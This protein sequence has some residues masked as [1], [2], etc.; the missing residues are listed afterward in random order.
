MKAYSFCS[1]PSNISKWHPWTDYCHIFQCHSAMQ[2]WADGPQNICINF[3]IKHSLLVSLTVHPW[4]AGCWA[5]KNRFTGVKINNITRTFEW[6]CPAGINISI[7]TKLDCKGAVCLNWLVVEK[8]TVWC[9]YTHIIS[10]LWST[11]SA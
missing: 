10:D 7:S 8:P 11:K 9:I 6:N 1:D 2:L 4:P 3:Q 5:H